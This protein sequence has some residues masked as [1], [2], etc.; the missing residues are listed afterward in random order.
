MGN[1]PFGIALL[2]LAVLSII[3]P[4]FFGD[5]KSKGISIDVN[6]DGDF[7]F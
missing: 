6:E 3:M 4:Y 2:I 7:L 1:L 5:E